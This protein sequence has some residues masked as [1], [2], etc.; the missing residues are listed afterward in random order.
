[1]R[2]VF[3]ELVDALGDELKMPIANNSHVQEHMRRAIV[4]LG[5]PW[6]GYLEEW[7]LNG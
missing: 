6:A 2:A 3:G 7:W 4:A 1:M 5:A